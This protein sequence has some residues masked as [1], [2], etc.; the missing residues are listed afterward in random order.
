[1]CSSFYVFYLHLVY[2]SRISSLE[3]PHDLLFIFLFY[4]IGAGITTLMSY[5]D[6]LDPY[7]FC[8]KMEKTRSSK[9]EL[10]GEVFISRQ[11]RQFSFID[12]MINVL[13]S[14]ST[15]NWR[16]KIYVSR[17]RKNINGRNGSTIFFI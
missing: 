6:G 2:F 11:S 16:V 3:N 9:E 14:I 17:Q 13:S 1:M 12:N 10:D 8:R 4:C 5:S 15:L 7:N